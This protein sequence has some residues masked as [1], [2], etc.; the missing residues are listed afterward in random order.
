MAERSLPETDFMSAVGTAETILI[1]VRE[2]R[3]FEAGHLSGARN[4]PLSQ[5]ST[6]PPPGWLEEAKLLLIYCQ[7]GQR[8]RHALELLLQHH[9]P[10]V[11]LSGGLNG[12][13][14][15]NTL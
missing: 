10:A 4:L 3:E 11:E 15:H 5:L 2:P 14:A 9:L 13:S 8:S 1:D 7:A 12:L 6:E